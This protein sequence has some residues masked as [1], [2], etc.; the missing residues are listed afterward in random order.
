MSQNRVARTRVPDERFVDAPTERSKVV[1]RPVPKIQASDAGLDGL[2]KAFSNFFSHFASA[3]NTMQQAVSYKEAEEIKQVNEE[4]K[5]QATA[6]ALSGSAMRPEMSNDLDYVNTYKDLSGSRQGTDMFKKWAETVLSKAQPTDDLNALTQGFLEQEWGRGTGDARYDASAL[7]KF[8]S[9]TDRPIT[10]F[11][12]NAVK[13]QLEVGRRN[14]DAEIGELFRTGQMDIDRYSL[15][16]QR[17]R[18]LNVT[19]PQDAPI[20]VFR[21]VLNANDGTPGYLQRLT[22]MMNQRGTGSAPDKSFVESFPEEAKKIEAG[23]VRDLVTVHTME[24][25][26]AW[27][28]LNERLSGVKKG[29]DVQHVLE[30]AAET[31]ERH[32]GMNEMEQFRGHLKTFLNKFAE[33]EAGINYID[34][35][36]SGVIPTFD[37]SVIEKL[38]PTYLERKGLNWQANPVETAAAVGEMRVMS[39]D[40]KT[41]VSSR[42]IDKTNPTQQLA[43]FQFYAALEERLGS[44]DAVLQMMDDGARM[45]YQ[46][47]YDRSYV[48]PSNVM[49]QLAVV[50]DAKVDYATLSKQS[51]KDLTGKD[52]KDVRSKLESKVNSKLNGW[53]DGVGTV[54][55]DHSTRETL[56]NFAKTEIHLRGG[57]QDWEKVLDQTIS[58]LGDRL[59]LVPGEGGTAQARIN[60]IPVGDPRTG[61][62]FVRLG[63]N[64]LNEF[65]KPENT[66]VTAQEDLKALQS[67]FPKRFQNEANVSLDGDTEFSL[68]GIYLVKNAGQR[69]AFG[70]GETYDNKG[71]SMVLPKDPQEAA[72]KLK[73]AFPN[74]RAVLI[75]YPHPDHPAG[76]L[77]GYKPGFKET[78]AALEA[79]IQERE[80]TFKVVPPT[81]MFP[82]IP[83]GT[84]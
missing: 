49:S 17:R 9:L 61:E 74:E 69:V 50:N 80:K 4:Q 84:D 76:F 51:W 39:P 73:E 21:A 65:G 34:Q 58:A 20:D 8:Q 82:E 44:R 54:T 6:D 36:R 42:L 43:A 53:F 19:N 60:R 67:A 66:L 77:L 33:T 83:Q 62:R 45:L 18:G 46:H 40:L 81:P 75:P 13:T 52:E 3:A 63:A 71:Q 56:M 27:F 79:K 70:L 55:L 47:V 30:L 11:R 15:E 2:N 57:G 68:K 72:Q 10:E 48:D 16:V 12:V 24:G 35:V 22:A 23:A 78:K 25:A 14:H 41:S 38:Q 5:A 29:E 32:G 1:E 26:K 7:A 28:D 37:K 31:Y 59:E 64:V